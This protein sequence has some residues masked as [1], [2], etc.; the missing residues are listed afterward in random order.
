MPNPPELSGSSAWTLVRIP[1]LGWRC[2]VGVLGGNS[3]KQCGCKKERRRR[4]RPWVRQPWPPPE[5]LEFFILPPSRDACLGFL[6]VWVIPSCQDTRSLS[7]LFQQKDSK[8]LLCFVFNQLA[9]SHKAMSEKASSSDNMINSFLRKNNKK[10]WL[11]SPLFCHYL[12]MV[13]Q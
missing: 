9:S 11:F 2:V 5:M 8:S 6:V 4:S 7:P 12:E 3:S 13:W 1:A 10:S